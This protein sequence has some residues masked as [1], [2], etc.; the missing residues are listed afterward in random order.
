MKKFTDTQLIQI[1]EHLKT[2]TPSEI[3]AF[4]VFHPNVLIR[5]N[6]VVTD[7]RKRIFEA[8]EA[9]GL[10]QNKVAKLADLNQSNFC[11]YLKGKRGMS[12]PELEK[13]MGV[14]GI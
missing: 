11:Q 8:M 5:G 4:K 9:R 1:S 2:L 6:C 3:E 13:V 10:N 14:L 12:S 7:L